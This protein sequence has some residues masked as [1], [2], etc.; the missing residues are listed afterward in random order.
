MAR[1]SFSLAPWQAAASYSPYDHF[2][3][4]GGVATGKSY[5]GSH[6]AIHMFET[7]PDLTGFIGANTY[8]QMSQATL[9]E[10]FYW[11]DYYGFE[12]VIDR[13]PPAEWGAGRRFKSYT[14]ILSVR[15]G[16]KV[17]YAFTRVLS[18]PDALR[19]V[20]FSWYWL[21]ETRD[22]PQN[23]HDVI[24]SRMRESEVKKGLITTTTNGED[25]CYSRFVRGNDGSLT[26]GS[27]H[28]PTIKSLELGIID[29]KYFNIMLK[30]YSPLMAAQELDAQHVNVLGGRAYYAASHSNKWSVSPWGDAAPVRERPLVIG[31]D[32]NFSP[33]PCVWMVG[34]VGPN[35]WVKVGGRWVWGADMIHW[36][37]ELAEVEIGSREMAMKLV[38][39]YPGFFYEFYGDMSG[40]MGTTSNAGETDFKQIGDEFARLGAVYSIVAEELGNDEVR[41]NPLVRNRVENMNAMFKNALG[42]IRQTYNPEACPLFDA[43]LRMVGWKKSIQ[44]GRGKLDDGGDSQR[45][46]GSDGAGYAVWK[47]FP[48]LWTSEIGA[49]L[50]SMTRTEINS[51]LPGRQ[52]S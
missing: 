16:D 48:P 32:F 11:L 27:M 25:W 38:A 19:G 39:R 37:G 23:T 43:D 52:G 35:L 36:F 20:E 7:R 12:F 47:K 4:F 41:R 49:G 13:I 2:A 8:D 28:I 45:T 46:H 44:S 21:D 40:N 9:R 30:S 42:E 14:N 22:T 33:A 10:L 5:T 51:V 34:Q 17:A 15:I 26:Y 29:E 3:M 18:D 24:L 6:F 1:A 50:P 31:A